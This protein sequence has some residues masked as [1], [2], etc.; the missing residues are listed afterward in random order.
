[1]L[2]F[3]IVIVIA[4]KTR[5]FRVC[6]IIGLHFVTQMVQKLLVVEPAESFFI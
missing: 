1:V 5:H 4:Q 2:V 3:V 6:Q